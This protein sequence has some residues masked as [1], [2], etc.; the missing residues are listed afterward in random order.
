ML[1][2]ESTMSLPGMEQESQEITEMSRQTAEFSPQ[3]SEFS[4][5]STEFLSVTASYPPPDLSSFEVD[6]HKVLWYSLG[7]QYTVFAGI[8]D[9][10]KEQGWQVS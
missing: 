9:Y 2:K 4:G 8:Y 10:I 3:V 1:Q 5:K 7:L 6:H